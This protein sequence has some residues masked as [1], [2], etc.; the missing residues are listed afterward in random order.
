MISHYTIN[1]E[2]VLE[3]DEYK[4]RIIDDGKTDWIRFCEY[5]ED[6]DCNLDGIDVDIARRMLIDHWLLDFRIKESGRKL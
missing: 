4:Y 5:L 1:D 6:E 2:V 3:I